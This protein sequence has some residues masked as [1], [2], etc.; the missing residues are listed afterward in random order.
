MKIL[1]VGLKEDFMVIDM[2]V[3]F[4]IQQDSGSRHMRSKGVKNGV[5]LLFLKKYRSDDTDFK[6]ERM[7]C[8]L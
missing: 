5:I 6:A 4:G 3:K 2:C 7:F 8:M 1:I